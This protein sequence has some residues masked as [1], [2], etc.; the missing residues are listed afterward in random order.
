[1]TRKEIVAM[2]LAGGEGKRLKSL[3]KSVAKPAVPFGGKYRI[4]DF[5]L[6]NC[7]NSDIDTVGVLT[8]YEPLLLNAY[9]G[10]GAAWD[11]NR[12][13][14]GLH[15]LPPYVQQQGG[16]WYKGT[17]NAIYENITFIE[18]YQPEYVLVIS[19]DHI[20]NMDYQEMLEEHKQNNADVTISVIEVPWDEA[21]RFGIMNTD[22]NDQ[23]LEFEEKPD[24]PQNNLASMGVY[25]FNWKKLKKYLIEDEKSE[26][27]GSDFGKDII[28]AMLNDDCSLFAYQFSGYWKD[29][30]T[31]DSLW[32]A[33]L[34]LLNDDCS[35]DLKDQKRRLRSVNLNLPPQFIGDHAIVKDSMINEGCIVLGEVDHSVVF[36][37]VEIGEGSLIKDAV[38]MPTAKIGKNVRIQRAVIG[39]GEIIPDGMIIGSEDGPIELVDQGSSYKKSVQLYA[40]QGGVNRL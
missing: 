8:Q 9:L 19:G 11:L 32:E 34:D 35:L 16:R 14:G 5:T 39:E 36:Y 4:I 28:P 22:E 20:Y 21:H 18:R 17:A 40:N 24:Y 30:G 2:L 33:N 23:I 31:I 29:V 37:G 10:V 38:I 13:N 25:I 1:M 6:S 15:I 27:S 12:K 7:T 26:L 3:T